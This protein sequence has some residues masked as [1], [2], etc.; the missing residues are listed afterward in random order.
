MPC[1]FL[2]NV[3]KGTVW[4]PNVLKP[5]HA[6]AMTILGGHALEIHCT[7]VVYTMLTPEGEVSGDDHGV[8]GF[9]LWHAG[10]TAFQKERL[11]DV[12][13]ALL[14]LHNISEGFDLTFHDLPPGESF[15]FRGRLVSA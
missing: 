8:H 1:L 4:D 13:Q 10:R 6:V 12:I 11:G 5:F 2:E 9:I 7:N 15:F 14:Y 3:P